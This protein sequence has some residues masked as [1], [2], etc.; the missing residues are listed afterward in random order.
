MFLSEANL[1]FNVYSPS[2]SPLPASPGVTPP[3]LPGPEP[4]PSLKITLFFTAGK[5]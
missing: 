4:P 5:N 1:M 2:S 3:L